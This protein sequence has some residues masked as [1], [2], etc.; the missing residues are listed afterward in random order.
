MPNLVELQYNPYIPNLSILID[1]KQP[2]DFSRLVQ[3]S[4]ED[5]WIWCWDIL[6]AVYSEIRNDFFVF[7]T[8]TVEDAKVLE[9]ICKQHKFCCG[10]KANDFIITESLQTRMK[11]LN[12]Y[13]KKKGITTYTKTVIDAVFLIPPKMQK[14]L[15]DIVS[16]DV[17]N[18]FCSVRVTTIGLNSDYDETKNSFLFLV[19][20]SDGIGT[21]R[22]ERFSTKK[23]AFVLVVGAQEGL[24]KIAKNGWYFG[25][26]AEGLFNTI[27]MCLL[28]APLL[29]AF[30]RCIKSIQQ[31]ADNTEF[32]KIYAIEPIINIGVSGE[33]EIGRSS[34]I[35]VSLDP[36]VGYAPKL[37]YKMIN[38]SVASCDGLCVFGK[39]E[40][41]A[42]LEV[43]R[44]GDKKPFCTKEI[45]VYK[46][47][48]IAK[49]ILSDDSI[50]LGKGD[51]N[52]IRCEYIP[53]NAD[54]ICSITWR[55]SDESIVKVDNNGTITA[56][57]VGNCR[58][59]CVA[60]NV[61][62]QCMCIVKPYLEEITFEFELEE[63]VMNLEPM[64]EIELKIGTYPDNC[65]DDALIIT[66]SDCNAVNAIKNTL[67]AK[68]K[69]ESIITVTN[70]NG[71]ISRSFKAIVAKKKVGFF[72]TIF[73]KK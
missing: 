34:K 40:G 49:I 69:G 4:D 52:R 23:P 8:G 16:I 30:R 42:N 9:R 66:S 1:G 2:P 33:I 65:V 48:R 18:L 70:S 6:D 32:Y 71:R 27:F 47:N 56:V 44:E 29:N 21:E 24:L 19:T 13:I 17:N 15:E 37:I 31:K 28:Q 38:Q 10:F 39:Q 5:I 11:K 73:N 57:G 60:E 22:L 67:Y 61:S 43:Y 14:Y 55:S 41:I 26:S 63:G 53:Q 12:Q 45:R 50:L 20:N 54:N 59:M 64:Q 3:Y 62:E 68:A 72:K 25:T 36:P 51:R 7:F 46:R 58:I 35:I